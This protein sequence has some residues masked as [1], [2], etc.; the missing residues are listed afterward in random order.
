MIY[1]VYC[2][3]LCKYH[4]VLLPSTT[5]KEREREKKGEKKR[6]EEQV[7]ERKSPLL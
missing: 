5:L 1:L 3:N 4:N 2:R 7:E 6:G